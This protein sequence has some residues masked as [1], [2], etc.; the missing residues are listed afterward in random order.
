MKRAIFLICLLILLPGFAFAA[1]AHGKPAAIW[2]PVINFSLYFCLMSFLYRKKIR[3]LL[4]ARKDKIVTQLRQASLEIEAAEEELVLV[5]ER[6]MALSSEK[7]ELREHYRMEAERLTENIVSSASLE[8]EQ[9]AR[10]A[11][12]QIQSYLRQAQ[13]EVKARLVREASARAKQILQQTLN[14][15]KDRVLRTR[16]L[17]Q[18]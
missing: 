1:G 18:F 11:E 3:P 12:R 16:A 5:Q 13:R 2:W 17:E 9:V 7:N 15:E 14:D 4:A 6:Y 10:D 8:A